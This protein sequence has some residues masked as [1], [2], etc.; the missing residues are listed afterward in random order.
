[1]D[2]ARAAWG[3]LPDWLEALALACDE[4][5]QRKV[6]VRLGYSVT[7]IS[8]VLANKYGG[9]PGTVAA[10]V[11]DVLVEGEVDCPTLGMI[12]RRDCLEAQTKPLATT[13]SAAVRQWK[14]CKD[15]EHNHGGKP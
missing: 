3:E 5:S 6:A 10:K 12:P 4:T 1:L 7:A 11:R 13:S 15:C 9:D 8:L 2:K 14:A